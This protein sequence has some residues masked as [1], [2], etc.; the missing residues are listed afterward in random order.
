MRVGCWEFQICGDSNVSLRFSHN[1]CLQVT[2]PDE[3]D[4]F[5]WDGCAACVGGVRIDFSVSGARD[6]N[7][8]V[9]QKGVVPGISWEVSDTQV[10]NFV[11]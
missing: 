8:D 5:V 3:G 2:P 7:P 11:A 4:F 10:Q 9:C 1:V 6:V